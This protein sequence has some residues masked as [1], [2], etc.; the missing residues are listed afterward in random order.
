VRREALACAGAA[1][2]F[3]GLLALALP[4]VEPIAVGRFFPRPLDLVLAC[5]FAGAAGLYIHK[6]ARSRCGFCWWMATFCLVSSVGHVYMAHAADTA[7]VWTG[8]AFVVNVGRYFA[9]LLGVSTELVTLFRRLKQR[10]EELAR[11]RRQLGRILGKVRGFNA[12][13]E[14]LVKERTAKLSCAHDRLKENQAQLVQAEKMAAIGQIAAGVAHEINNPLGFVMSNLGTL[15]EYVGAFKRVLDENDALVRSVREVPAAGTGASAAVRAI[16]RIAEEED[17]P[18][19]REDVDQ[20]LEECDQG[21]QRVK[22]IVQ[23]LK[24]F[25]RPDEPEAREADVNECIESTLKLVWNELKYTC[26]VHKRLAP[27]PRVRCYPGQLNQVFMNLLVNAAQAIPEQ[28]D[29]SI[30]TALDG[31]DLVIRI[32][33]TGAG[34]DAGNLPRLFEPFFTTKPVGQGTGLGLSIAH[35][36]VKRHNGT[37]EVASKPGKGTT[38]T[39]RLPREGVPHEEAEHS[40]R[41]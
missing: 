41:R 35:R 19:V 40:V 15:K 37:I 4:A 3:A 7:G 9:P 39:V 32:A 14:G 22:E 33:D 12:R 29:V 23:N 27:L 31:E 11:S 34:I 2:C 8:A 20:L 18:A 17:L 1:F 26:R 36:I 10:S 13:L 6:Y 30:E 28:G 25:A 21:V 16:D 5:L 38:F 24:N